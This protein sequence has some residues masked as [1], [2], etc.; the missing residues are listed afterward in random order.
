MTL[1]VFC[2]REMNLA[3]LA[4]SVL[5]SELLASSAKILFVLGSCLEISAETGGS[6][7]G[8]V[9]TKCQTVPALKTW[10]SK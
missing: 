5:K 1:Y 6:V 9:Q 8:A 2:E 7:L 4:H 10:K 3:T